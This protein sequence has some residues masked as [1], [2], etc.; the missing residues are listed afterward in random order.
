MIADIVLIVFHSICAA[1]HLVIR[2]SARIVVVYGIFYLIFFSIDNGN[3]DSS[4]SGILGL[5][6]S[7]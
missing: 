3:G 4:V 5:P 2:W 1:I 6:L 7:A